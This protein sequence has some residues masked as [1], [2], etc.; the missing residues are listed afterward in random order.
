MLLGTV[1][2]VVAYFTGHLEVVQLLRQHNASWDLLDKTGSTALHWAVDG[3]NLDMIRWM[4]QDGCRVDVKDETSGDCKINYY[5]IYFLNCS[6]I[7][8]FV[9]FIFTLH[10]EDINI[11]MS[12]AMFALIKCQTS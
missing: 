11:F 10:S 1:I 4:L 5:F 6:E 7:Q 2:I 9:N 3:A 8:G 12:A